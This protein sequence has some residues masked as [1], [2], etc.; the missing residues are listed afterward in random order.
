MADI[1]GDSLPDLL[2][3]ETSGAREAVYY[4]Q[5]PNGT[6]GDRTVLPFGTQIYRI[7]VGDVNQD[8]VIDLLSSQLVSSTYN[9]RWSNGKG[10]ATLAAHNS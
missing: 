10:N 6:F 3:V 9:L 7:F 1:T 4:P 2:A 5:N 8:G